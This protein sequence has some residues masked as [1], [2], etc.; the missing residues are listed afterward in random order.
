[1][2]AGLLLDEG[3]RSVGAAVIPAGVGGSE[4][5]AKLVIELGVTCI[6]AS[7]AFFVTLAETIEGMGKKLP[8]AWQ[9]KSAL[10][11]GEFGDWLGKRAPARGKVWHPNLRGLC[12][13]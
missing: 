12:H 2:P 7:T 11:G 10:L 5:Q 4:L 13:R 9:V 8:E 3:L 6:C 1:M